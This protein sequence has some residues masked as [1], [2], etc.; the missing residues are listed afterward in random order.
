[1]HL[2]HSLIAKLSPQPPPRPQTQ[3]KR[4]ALFHDLIVAS[5]PYAGRDSIASPCLPIND[6]LLH[7]THSK[8]S[9]YLCKKFEQGCDFWRMRTCL[10]KRL[11]YRRTN[12]QD[13]AGRTVFNDA[14]SKNLD[15][16]MTEFHCLRRLQGSH[17]AVQLLGMLHENTRSKEDMKFFYQFLKLGDRRSKGIRNVCFLLEEMNEGSL[18]EQIDAIMN[19]K[20]QPFTEEKVV[21]YSCQLA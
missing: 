19:K 6:E 1:M 5:Q 10:L 12:K 4:L 13:A 9:F 14:E 7:Y 2:T 18:K 11:A 20:K 15:Q 3:S 16:V 21:E 17:R 8:T